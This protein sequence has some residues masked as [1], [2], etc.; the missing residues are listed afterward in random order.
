MAGV[1]SVRGA[2]REE[3]IAADFTSL[4]RDIPLVPA[5]EERARAIVAVERAQQIVNEVPLDS[6]IT[7]SRQQQIAALEKEVR[8]LRT[9]LESRDAIEQAKGIIMATSGCDPDTAFDML[10]QQSQHENRKLRDVA[11]EL[12]AQQARRRADA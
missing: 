3:E 9:A 4:F 12:V 10:R 7:S 2:A 6:D 1:S 5:V 8:G 11:V